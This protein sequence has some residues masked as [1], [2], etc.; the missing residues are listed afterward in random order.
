ML[1]INY[2][3]GT[4]DVASVAW[5]LCWDGGRSLV[6]ICIRID[7]VIDYSWLEWVGGWVGGGLNTTDIRYSL[8]A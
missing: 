1:N 6:R 3:G 4:G 5:L 8:N 2:W 7:Y